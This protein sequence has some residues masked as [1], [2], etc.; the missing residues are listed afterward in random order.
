MGTVNLMPKLNQTGV[1]SPFIIAV[2]AIVVIGGIFVISRNAG[3]SQKSSQPQE[4][5]QEQ[6]AIVPDPSSIQ[7]KTY[8]DEER[9]YSIKHPEGWTVENSES[10]NSRLIKIVAGDKFAFVIIEAIG[11]SSLDEDGAVEGVVKYMEEKLDKN[12][13]LKV[14]A[15]TKQFEG[16]SGGYMAEGEYLDDGKEASENKKI[17][18]E[19]RFTVAKNG[20]GMRIHR[21]Y[22]KIT[23]TV[24]NS[25]TSEIIKSFSIN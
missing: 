21:A 3:N 10:G 7:W 5:E 16:D 22:A 24:N 12:T 17:L 11:G 8:K 15:F 9:G 23:Q 20:R 25:V 18:F 19:E 2:I 6:K 4:Q 1:I 13:D 14:T